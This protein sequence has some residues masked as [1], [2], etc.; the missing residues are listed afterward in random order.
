MTR[1]RYRRLASVLFALLAIGVLPGA[2]RARA[3]SALDLLPLEV[4][5]TWT[6]LRDGEEAIMTVVESNTVGEETIFVLEQIS[7]L[8]A[9]GLQ[10]GTND[11]N[12]LRTHRIFLPEPNGGDEVYTPPLLALE[13]EFAAP[14]GFSE[15]GTVALTITGVGTFPG[16]YQND[17]SIIGL[18]TVNVPAG[19]FQALRVDSVL[20]ITVNVLGTPVEITAS[21]SEWFVSGIGIVKSASLIDGESH[22]SELVSTNVPEPEVYLLQTAALLAVALVCGWRSGGGLLP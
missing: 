4:G 15:S 14:S 12:G 13:A 22:L 21:G 19:T 6:Y 20:G 5:N 10:F 9:G 8:Y 17:V 7:G 18:E 16:A 11:E 2:T 3:F 1:T